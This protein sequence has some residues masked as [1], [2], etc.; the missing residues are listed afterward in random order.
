MEVPRIPCRYKAVRC[1]LVFK[2]TYAKKKVPQVAVNS[3]LVH[4]ELGISV[5]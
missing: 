5:E 2:V 3:R 1:S 4:I